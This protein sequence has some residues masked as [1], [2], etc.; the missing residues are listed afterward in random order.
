MTV[1]PKGNIP[2]D[3][4]KCRNISCTNFLGKVLE[5]LVLTY[6]KKSVRPKPNQFGG[7]KPCSTNHFLAEVWDELTSHLED[8]RAAVALTSIDYSKAFNRLEH[9]ACLESFA[10]LGAS[11]QLIRLLASFL[12]GR[13][14]TVKIGNT[15]SK[16]R[17]VHA[18]APQGSVLGTYMFNIGTDSLEDNF[19]HPMRERMYQ[20]EM[21]DLSFLELTPITINAQSTADKRPTVL[22]QPDISPIATNRADLNYVILPTARNV[23]QEI[24][25]RVEPTWRPKPISVNKFVDDNLS[26]EKI[27]MPEVPVLEDDSEIYKNARA[28]Q[29]EALFRHITANAEKKAL[30]INA[31][32][33]TLLVI[34]P[35]GSLYL[36]HEDTGHP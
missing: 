11:N 16:L 12:A 18:G 36:L 35:G 29:S 31:D 28:G 1:I 32:R 14:M 13:N 7:E 3:P 23:P 30:R 34:G 27:Y 20:L 22:T 9:Q 4:S 19:E 6:A 15:F 21:G 8:S 10:Q 25:N 17:P 2:E 26:N 5:R 24:S 33:T